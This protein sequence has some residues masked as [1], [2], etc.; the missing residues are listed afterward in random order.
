MCKNTSGSEP[1]E[2]RPR[3]VVK[4]RVLTPHAAASV[5]ASLRVRVN[6]VDS[7]HES[8]DLFEERFVARNRQRPRV[9]GESVLLLGVAEQPPENGVIQVSGAD[10]E[11][12]GTAPHAD[13]HVSRRHVRRKSVR[14][15]LPPP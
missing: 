7:G 2:Q 11:P 4:I 10:D 6:R 14:C 1:I 13:R 12:P 15:G 8:E 9:I 3:F 5:A